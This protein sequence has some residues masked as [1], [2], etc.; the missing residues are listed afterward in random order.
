MWEIFRN[1]AAGHRL[2]VEETFDFRCGIVNA[3][4]RHVRSCATAI[5]THCHA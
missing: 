3:T 5:E 1:P 4:S 2:F